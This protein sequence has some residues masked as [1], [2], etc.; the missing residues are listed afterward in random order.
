MEKNNQNQ[1]ER[2]RQGDVIKNAVQAT[3]EK[4]AIIE[5]TLSDF[6]KIKS[7]LKRD[8]NDMAEGRLDRIVER[9]G[10]DTVSKNESAFI[11][12]SKIEIGSKTVSP[13]YVPYLLTFRSDNNA[14]EINNSIAKTYAKGSYKI[15]SGE[16]K[17][18]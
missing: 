10:M 3:F 8:L 6:Q 1:E 16:I 12:T 13:W 15:K 9:Q 18:L 11:V 4:L 2:E 14:K 7:V 17:Y 5:S